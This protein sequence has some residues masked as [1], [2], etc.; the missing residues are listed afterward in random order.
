MDTKTI[1]SSFQPGY[2][3]ECIYRTKNDQCRNKEYKQ[4]M[5]KVI[6]VWGYCKYKKLKQKG[7]K[8]G[9]TNH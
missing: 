3:K 5:Y 7:D 8:D 6:G 1:L 2:C 4:N 9:E